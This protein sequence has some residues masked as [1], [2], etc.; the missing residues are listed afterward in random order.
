M[1]NYNPELCEE[2]RK[3]FKNLELNYKTTKE[4]KKKNI[5]IIRL[6]LEGSTFYKKCNLLLNSPFDYRFFKTMIKISKKFLKENMMRL[7]KNNVYIITHSD[8]ISIIIKDLEWHNNKEQKIISKLGSYFSI[9]FFKEMKKMV[10]ITLNEYSKYEINKDYNYNFK[11]IFQNIKKSDLY[12][13]KK[14][15]YK[16]DPLFD[17]RIFN[18]FKE[19]IPK[20]N[21]WRECNCYNSGIR[22]I[23]PQYYNLSIK[24]IE[25][26]E[27]LKKDGYYKIK[28]N[29]KFI[30]MNYIYIEDINIDNLDKNKSL[31]KYKIIVKNIIYNN[32]TF[33][34]NFFF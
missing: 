24:K 20:Y 10:K 7:K 8:E 31:K 25:N 32:D 16:C 34:N 17:C 3:Y 26:I 21:F 2:Y 6:D 22:Y 28:N 29:L 30:K 1:E 14:L 23:F 13:F 5:T 9:K 19:D 12:N 18:C 15:S 11:E 4:D 33:I 27:N